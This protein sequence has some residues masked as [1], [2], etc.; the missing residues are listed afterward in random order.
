[1]TVLV[2]LSAG[3]LVLAENDDR[4][5]DH[6]MRKTSR[7]EMKQD[8]SNNRKEIR[9]GRGNFHDE[10]G[11]LTTY[12]KSNLTTEEKQTVRTLLGEHQTA[13]KE[14][15]DTFIEVFT[16]SDSADDQ[17]A[18]FVD[19]LVD[20]KLELYDD[21]LPFIDPEKEDEY[22]TYVDAFLEQFAINFTKRLQN[23][24]DHKE[25]KMK[26]QIVRSHPFP[27]RFAGMVNKFMK[28]RS[29]DDKAD[30]LQNVLAKIEKKIDQIEA[31]DALPEATKQRLLDFLG[32]L[33]DMV[34]EEYNNLLTDSDDITQM[35]L[36]NEIFWFKQKKMSDD[37][38]D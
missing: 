15:T 4:K 26:N 32:D 6:G 36:L 7:M 23:F 28:K 17:I 3:G 34:Q 27:S 29:D 11:H 30:F 16:S 14:K 1:M 19:E 18:D 20:L 21:L 38:E 22:Q 10:R 2:A 31:H 37:D 33:Y 24:L 12:L 35:S 5:E 13:L 9:D 8:I 25:M